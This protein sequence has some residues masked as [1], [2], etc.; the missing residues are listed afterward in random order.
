MISSTAGRT[1]DGGVIGSQAADGR[2]ARS[3]EVEFRNET[4]HPLQ[5]VSACHG[6]DNSWVLAP[7]PLVAPGDTAS[8]RASSARRAAG[9]VVIYRDPVRGARVTFCGRTS[10]QR[11]G[12]CCYGTPTDGLLV[13]GPQGYQPGI[14]A[15]IHAAYVL[16]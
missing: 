7:P 8:F 14:H 9:G 5:L 16:G 4:G 3:Y 12:S 1:E 6:A 11:G 13:N 2:D 10:A 15:R